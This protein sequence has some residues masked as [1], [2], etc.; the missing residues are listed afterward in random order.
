MR[1]GSRAFPRGPNGVP[2]WLIKVDRATG[3]LLGYVEAI[4]V[5][6]I[7]VMG[8]GDLLQAP[9]PHGKPQRYTAA[10]ARPRP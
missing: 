1:C 5:H 4:G 8:N 9:G 10:P 7:E 3:R 6:G 2:G